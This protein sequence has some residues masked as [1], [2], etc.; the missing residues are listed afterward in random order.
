MMNW[1]PTLGLQ[2]G[3]ASNAVL[4]ETNRLL[5]CGP[6]GELSSGFLTDLGGSSCDTQYLQ[7]VSNEIGYTSKYKLY[8]FDSQVTV[9]LI[10]SPI[11]PI[12]T[13]PNF[14]ECQVGGSNWDPTEYT[15]TAGRTSIYS[16]TYT[17]SVR[18]NS[19][20]DA[21]HKETSSFAITESTAASPAPFT[22]VRT[23]HFQSW[24]LDQLS[25]SITGDS[26]WDWLPKP[27]TFSLRYVS[28]VQ[29]GHRLRL[30]IFPIFAFPL[31]FLQKSLT[32]VEL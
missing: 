16:F 15:F 27:Y 7:I 32:I 24:V 13:P 30:E 6:D 4:R 3:A 10:G 23:R 5:F 21:D 18:M 12:N 22:L 11:I 26:F 8:I 25:A 1:D 9:S 14:F 29:A 28:L 19:T 2:F 31:V 17:I 20:N